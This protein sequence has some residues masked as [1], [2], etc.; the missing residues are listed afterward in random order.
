VSLDWHCGELEEGLACYSGGKFFLA[1]E[2]WESVWLSLEEPEKSFLQALIQVTAAFHHLDAGNPAGALSLL[3]RA[4][5]RLD[6]FPAQS[7]GIELAPFR[8]KVAEWMLALE[9]GTALLP[10]TR[11]KILPLR[12]V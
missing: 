4:L 1:H 5:L 8:G 10:A 11:P 9:R 2:H 7:G 6:Q 3:R 12:H